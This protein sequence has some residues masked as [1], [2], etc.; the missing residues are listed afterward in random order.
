MP[1]LSHNCFAKLEVQRSRKNE[2]IVMKQSQGKGN[3]PVSYQHAQGAF[4]FTSHTIK[5]LSIFFK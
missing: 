1:E 5:G 4:M 3:K 2:E